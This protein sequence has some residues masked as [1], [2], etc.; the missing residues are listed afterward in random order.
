MR[1]NGIA[2]TSSRG[3]GKGGSGGTCNGGGGGCGGLS[4]RAGCNKDM[5]CTWR[6]LLLVGKDRFSMLFL[7]QRYRRTGRP[8]DRQTLEIKYRKM[9]RKDDEMDFQIRKD[10]HVPPFL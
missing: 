6:D 9:S 8:T 4:G 5:Q 2:I 3:N 10:N 1:E 7:R